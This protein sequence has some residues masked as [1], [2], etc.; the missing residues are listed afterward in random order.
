MRASCAIALCC[1]AAAGSAQASFG[2]QLRNLCF[3][4]ARTPL[5]CTHEL[6]QL[7]DGSWQP[8]WRKPNPFRTRDGP[9]SSLNG[10]SATSLLLRA[11]QLQQQGEFIAAAAAAHQAAA[12]FHAPAMAAVLELLP[13][14]LAEEASLLAAADAARAKLAASAAKLDPCRWQALAAAWTEQLAV[15]HAGHR[16]AGDRSSPEV[17]AVRCAFQSAFTATMQDHDAPL[18]GGAAGIDCTATASDGPHL[19]CRRFS[20][21]DVL[22]AASG[23][24][25]HGSGS[26]L[27][28]GAAAD[29]S[30]S[31]SFLAGQWFNTPESFPAGQW[32]NKGVSSRLLQW[33]SALFPAV[34]DQP[35]DKLG[36]DGHGHPRNES[37]VSSVELPVPEMV[38]AAAAAQPNS[39]SLRVGAWR[40]ADIRV[41]AHI[42]PAPDLV[43]SLMQDFETWLC[44]DA[45][46]RLHPLQQAA[47]A[48]AELLWIHPFGDGNGR[49]ARLLG[50][51]ILAAHGWPPLTLPASV[52]EMY[53]HAAAVAHPA[54]GGCTAPIVQLLAVRMVEQ[55]GEMVS[56]LATQ[57]PEAE[58]PVTAS[59]D[60]VASGEI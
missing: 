19:L 11:S 24:T 41:S 17:A 28:P 34:A 16:Q 36:N 21:F 38:T 1:F 50:A 58:P 43:P 60:A 47:L 12:R 23:T 49:V 42:G 4:S 35:V 37:L 13:L 20:W 25:A 14:A 55:I 5:S 52:R 46:A 29:T 59:D 54:G 26:T 7:S 27:D 30:A 10:G 32:I 44:S 51:S 3:A 39:V 57:Q 15:E 56:W 8:A 2:S 9:P 40:L 22:T 45:F 6:R 31:E 18:S 33:H 48:M 53:L